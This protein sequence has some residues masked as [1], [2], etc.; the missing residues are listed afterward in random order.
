MLCERRGAGAT[1]LRAGS[2]VVTHLFFGVYLGLMVWGG[3]L[4]RDERLRTLVPLPLGRAP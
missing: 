1:H 3:L 4:L 2:P